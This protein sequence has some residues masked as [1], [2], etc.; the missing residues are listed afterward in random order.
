MPANTPRPIGRTESFFPGMEKLAPG[1]CW[2]AA[3]EGEPGVETA[4]A[5]VVGVAIGGASGVVVGV[6]TESGD[7]PVGVAG[8]FTV[9]TPLTDNGAASAVGEGTVVVGNVDTVVVKPVDDTAAAPGAFDSL[10]FLTSWTA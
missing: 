2:A 6:E 4:L 1:D 9:E 10:Q 5:A 7:S 3:A 8:E